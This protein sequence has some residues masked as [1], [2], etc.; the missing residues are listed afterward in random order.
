[1]ALKSEKI[2]IKKKNLHLPDEARE[3]ENF[4][5][6]HTASTLFSDTEINSKENQVREW[7]ASGQW[8]GDCDGGR[9]FF[10]NEPYRVIYSLNCAHANL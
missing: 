9:L 8:N 7:K 2:K 5:K 1:M 6:G 10:N 4:K 3:S